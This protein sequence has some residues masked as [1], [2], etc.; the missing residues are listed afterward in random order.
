MPVVRADEI[1]V[2]GFGEVLA[3]LAGGHGRQRLWSKLGQGSRSDG[4]G[5][6]DSVLARISPK[7]SA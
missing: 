6:R 3:G 1:E 4:L 2:E 7:D 5:E